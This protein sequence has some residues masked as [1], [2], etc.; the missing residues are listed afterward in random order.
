MKAISSLFVFALCLG[1]A[2]PTFAALAIDGSVTTS[3]GSPSQIVALTTTNKNDVII[4]FACSG[5]TNNGAVQTISDVASLTWKLR[6]SSSFN[7]GTEFCDEW[8]AISPNIL[9]ADNITVTWALNAG[10][11]TAFGISGADISYPFDNNASV[12]ATNS[13][14]T[15]STISI[16]GISTNNPSDIL[17]TM[18]RGFA[19]LSTVTRPTSF[20]QV[21]ATGASQDVAYNIVSAVASSTT[22]TYSWTGGAQNAIMLFDAIKAYNVDFLFQG[23]P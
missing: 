11:T 1:Y 22:Y 2:F 7:A 9:S 8:W 23:S 18:M 4:V 20:T 16:A 6:K 14:V 10:R 12:P 19:T 5:P 3:T 15:A 21:L 17:I 13:A